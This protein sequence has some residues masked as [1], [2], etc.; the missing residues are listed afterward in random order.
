MEE[1]KKQK[2]TWTFELILC[3]PI[4]PGWSYKNMLSLSLFFAIS[5]CS[6]GLLIFLYSKFIG[7][8]FLLR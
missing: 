3:L 4:L 2:Y 1:D 7:G 8:F 6:D 5:F